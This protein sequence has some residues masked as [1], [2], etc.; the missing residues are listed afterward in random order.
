MNTAWDFNLNYSSNLLGPNN[1]SCICIYGGVPS[2][3]VEYI[4]TMRSAATGYFEI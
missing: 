1:C 4:C 3:E 2:V